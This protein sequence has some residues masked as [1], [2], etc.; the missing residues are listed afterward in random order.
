MSV[1]SDDPPADSKPLNFLVFLTDQQRA[2]HVG[3]GG[4]PDLQ[5]PNL[6]AL[7]RRSVVFDRAHVASPVC[8]P[9]RASLITGR[10][11]SA[12]GTRI[13][14]ISLDWDAATF[15][16]VLKRAGWRTIHVGKAH[17]QNMGW[18]AHEIAGALGSTLAGDAVERDRPAGWNT[19]E[20]MERHRREWVEVPPDFYG[21]ERVE[22]VSG[23]SDYASGHYYQWA[24]ERGVE[25]DDVRGRERAAR[26]Y[27]GWDQ[28]YQSSLPEELYPTSYVT[29]RAVANLEECARDE[30]PFLLHC[31][32][33][34][35]HHPFTP[36]GRFYDLYDPAELALPPTFDDPHTRS[37]PHIRWIHERRGT[38]QLHPMML[39]AP[40]EDQLR[41]AL[42]AEYGMITMIDES[43]GTILQALSRLG[44]ADRTVVVFTSDHGDMFGDHG[45]LLKLNVSYQACLRVPLLVHVPGLAPGR[46][47]ALVSGIDLAP[48]VLGLAGCAGYRGLQGKSMEPLL[49]AAAPGVRDHLVVEEDRLQG[50][51]GLPTPTRIRTVVT[52]SARLTLY[53]GVEGGELFDLASDPAELEN[54]FDDRGSRSLRSAMSET[55]LAG[56]LELYDD[57]VAPTDSA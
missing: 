38:Q 50:I 20:D 37:M 11:P 35:P 45:L 21:F 48:T 8:M 39:W 34:D 30:R 54:R 16:R 2:D 31:S 4:N 9:S 18:G 29:E 12:H 26:R 22:L 47:D 36:P 15:P 27:D 7:A 42:A 6:D 32:Y 57:G 28:I 17:W 13:N 44:L 55:L 10:M 5:T 14:G 53:Q 43:V 23:H 40:T 25:L 49:E 24:R 1:A 3:F 33:P 46:R 51:P 41:H 52:E 19:W 56:M